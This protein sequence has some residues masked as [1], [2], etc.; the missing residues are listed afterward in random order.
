MFICLR[1]RYSWFRLS[2]LSKRCLYTKSSWKI[3]IG[4]PVLFQKWPVNKA[5]T[6][7]LSKYPRVW[8][9]ALPHKIWQA[10]Q[11]PCASRA[12]QPV[13]SGSPANAWGGFTCLLVPLLC[14]PSFLFWDWTKY[15]VLSSV[16]ILSCSIWDGIEY[17]LS[18]WPCFQ[19]ILWYLLFSEF[20]HNI[21]SY[22]VTCSLMWF[23]LKISSPRKAN[24]PLIL[25]EKR[26]A[27]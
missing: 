24:F 11:P 10:M 8:T 25:M 22:R 13:G 6:S 7:V 19:I 15:L 2:Y 21:S 9:P 17:K 1:T 23:L 18:S 16:C 27:T 4:M 20:F 5:R 3:K 26:L 12:H 14:I